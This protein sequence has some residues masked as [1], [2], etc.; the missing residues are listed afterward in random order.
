MRNKKQA[1]IYAETL[2][3]DKKYIPNT[4]YSNFR[5]TINKLTIKK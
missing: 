4:S 3:K 1:E 2:N 5:K